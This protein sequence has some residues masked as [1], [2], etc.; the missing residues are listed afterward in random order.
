MV[1]LFIMLAIVLWYVI[2]WFKRAIDTLPDKPR[3]LLILAA[4]LAGGVALSLQ[5]KLDAFVVAA[6]V[7]GLS[8]VEVTLIG[9]VFA[10]LILASEAGGAH[11]LITA[12]QGWKD[13]DD[14]IPVIHV[15]GPANG[16]VQEAPKGMANT[17]V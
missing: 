10:G 9:Q 8:D 12:L 5:F 15:S 2:D 16:S 6:Q 7:M 17:N 4:A 3:K 13:L 1:G 11:K 14:V